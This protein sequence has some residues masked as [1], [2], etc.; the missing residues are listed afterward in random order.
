[1]P[2]GD[3]VF[4]TGKKLE[5]ALAGQRLTRTDFRHPALATT[6]LSGHDVLGVRT[7]GKHLFLR[8]SGELSLHSHL[9]MDGSWRVFA[10]GARWNMPAHHARVVLTT[11]TTEAVGFRVHDLV[12]LPTDEERRLVGHLGPDLL[13]PEWTDEHAAIA[14]RTLASRPELELG[15]ALLDQRVMAGVG[16]LYKCEICFLL[17]VTPW[18]PVSE[19]DPAETVALARKLLRANAWRYDQSTTG[20][21]A[22]GRR[23]WVYERTRQGCF[24]CGGRV[25]VATQGAGV[26]GRPTWYCPNCQRGPAPAR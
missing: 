19:V 22:R 5:R 20:E 6:D 11:E 26:Q 7:V 12:L 14:A 25:R 16:N 9:K 21:T 13:D 18:T 10:R 15:L 17:G 3:T 4:L 23:N 2:E 8:F 1:M 24:R